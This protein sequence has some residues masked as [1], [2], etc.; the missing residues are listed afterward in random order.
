MAVRATSRLLVQALIRV[1][2]AEGGFAAVLHKGDAVAGTIL[3]QMLG[4]E[5]QISLFERVPDFSKGYVL[6][7]AATE[8]WG[9]SSSITQYIERRCRVD[10]DLWVVELDIANEQQLAAA[11]LDQD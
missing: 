1:T 7:P 5:Q 11:I 10:P 9:D 3:V 4:A 6:A 8:S 2:E